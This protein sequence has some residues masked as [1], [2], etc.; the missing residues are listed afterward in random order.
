MTTRRSCERTA[1]SSRVCTSRPPAT[2]LYSRSW[3]TGLS[4]SPTC[5]TR[6]SLFVA[7]AAP[8]HRGHAG[9]EN[10]FDELPLQNR[11]VAAAS[12]SR[13]TAMMPPN[14]EVG[15]VRYARAYASASV[16]AKRDAARIRV[17]HDDARRSLE[18]AHAF[19]R[20]I[21]VRDVVVRKLLALEL[22]RLRH[23]CADGARIGVERR[24]LVRVLAVAQIAC[25]RND[26]FR[27]SGKRRGAPADR[28]GEVCRYHGIVLRGMR[29]RLG[30][31]LLAHDDV[32]RTLVGRQF[33]ERGCD[34]RPDRRRR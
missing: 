8:W 23:R 17:L 14:A 28:A 24:L 19:E 21:A 31:E 18:L 30:R 10:H 12:K 32:G 2:L 15:S 20:G 6:T 29:K 3:V 1:A 4:R 25:L 13:L 22:R 7:R 27:S 11:L 5:S 33:I 34:S 26:R 9:R 16:A